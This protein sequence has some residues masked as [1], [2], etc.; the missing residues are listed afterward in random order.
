MTTAKTGRAS[1]PSSSA[2]ANSAT[3]SRRTCIRAARSN[4]GAAQPDAGRQHR[5]PRHNWSTGSSYNEGTLGDNDLIATSMPLKLARK[6]HALVTEKSKELDKDLLEDLARV[7][8][9]LDFGEDGSPAG[10]QIL[11]QGGGG[12]YFQC[13]LLRFDCEGRDRAEAVFG[14]RKLRCRG[15][16]G[17][18]TAKPLP[19]T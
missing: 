14:H 5:T 1:A 10:N 15:R 16:G 17:R 4:A 7:G 11:S 13:R 3:T 18:R 9:K 8:F 2:P 12:Y 19:P 6:S